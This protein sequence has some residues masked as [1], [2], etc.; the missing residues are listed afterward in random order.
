MYIIFIRHGQTD[1]NKSNITQGSEVDP[2]INKFGILQA[3]KTGEFIQKNFIIDKIYTSPLL[4]AKNTAKII[5]KKLNFKNKIIEDKTIIEVSKGILSGKNKNEV[6]EFIN[7]NKELKKISNLRK[8]NNFKYL[9]NYEKYFNIWSNI[10]KAENLDK[11]KDRTLNFFNKIKS[12]KG[13]IIVITHGSFIDHLVYN[14]TYS[15]QTPKNSIKGTQSNCS[16]TIIKIINDEY[17]FITIKNN[18]HLLNLYK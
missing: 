1:F 7:K 3:E 11:I 5:S 14:L 15:N 10:V 12:N 8:N 17:K 13:N 6:N 18:Y 4:R 16:L 9:L 2:D